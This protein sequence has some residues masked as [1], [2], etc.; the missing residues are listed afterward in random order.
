M[1]VSILVFLDQALKDGEEQRFAASDLFV[2]ILVFLD[3]ALKGF[4]GPVSNRTP[5]VSILVFLDQALK[6][7]HGLP[8]RSAIESFNPCFPGSS[9][10]RMTCRP[11]L[12]SYICFNPCFP[13]S[14]AESD[15]TPMINQK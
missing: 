9:A 12:P 4:L 8:N 1:R 11:Q 10:E 3:Q 14:S 5:G 15:K 2:S 13:G 7:Q 6:A